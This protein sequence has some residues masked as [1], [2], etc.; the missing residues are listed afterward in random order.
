[1]QR[2]VASTGESAL[3]GCL[4]EDCAF[5]YVEKVVTPQPLRVDV[6]LGIPRPLHSTSTGQVL[7]A[8]SPPDLMRSLLDKPGNGLG[9]GERAA[10]LTTIAQVRARGYAMVSDAKSSYAFG[11]AAPIRDG[12]G[13]LVAALNV[14][15]PSARFHQASEKVTREVVLAAAAITQELAGYGMVLERADVGGEVVNG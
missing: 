13:D 3:L 5:E 4:R 14:T 11:V 7:L 15:A 10:L 8:F 9:A 12:R 6:D 1:M 2:L